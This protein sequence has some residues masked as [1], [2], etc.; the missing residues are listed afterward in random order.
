[1]KLARTFSIG[2]RAI[3]SLLIRPLYN[4]TFVIHYVSYA[5]GP[6][7]HPRAH[8]PLQGGICSGLPWRVTKI[9]FSLGASGLSEMRITDTI[10]LLPCENLPDTALVLRRDAR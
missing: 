9:A 5:D 4:A 1:M 8:H 6:P 3:L 2:S 7:T 10:R